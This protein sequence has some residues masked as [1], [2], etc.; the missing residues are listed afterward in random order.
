MPVS[1]LALA[2]LVVAIWG[3]N[4]V[5]IDFGLAHFPP[6]TFA[7]LRFLLASFPLLLF[8]PRP[9]IALAG[10]AAYGL[11]S[12]VG[13][14]GLMLYA[15]AGHISPGLASL[16]V[17]TQAFFTVGL[18][19]LIAREPVRAGNL[20]ALALCAAGVALIAAN[21]GGGADPAGILLVLAA[22]LSWGGANMVVKRAGA[23]DML[24]FVVWSGPVAAGPLLAAALV[25]E[26]WPEMTASL[27]HAGPGAWANLLW[28]AFGNAVFGYAAWNW[29]LSRHPAAEVAPMGLLVPVFGLS[30]S[31]WFVAEPMP[32]WKLA[33]AA[34]VLAGLAI[35]LLASRRAAGPSS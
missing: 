18:A 24:A 1:H 2:L 31:A 30:A 8:V 25:L 29:L 23:I 35:N 21:I 7:A 4:F 26:G 10:L 9:R 5:V 14:F 20:A 28:Q 19:A 11:L 6:L 13:L 32:F 17:Q 3:T 12:G 27:A 33:A 22:A 34:L 15:L 16:L